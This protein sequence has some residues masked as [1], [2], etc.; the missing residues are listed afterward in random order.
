M[1]VGRRASSSAEIDEIEAAYLAEL[2]L[3]LPFWDGETGD[4]E[5]L[6][7][8]DFEMLKAAGVTPEEWEDTRSIGSPRR[9]K[10]MTN[11]LRTNMIRQAVGIA[12][13]KELPITVENVSRFLPGP[14]ADP[15]LKGAGG[16]LLIEQA[17]FELDATRSWSHGRRAN[18]HP[19]RPSF[20]KASTSRPV[21]ALPAPAPEKKLSRPERFALASDFAVQLEHQ[22]VD[23]RVELETANRNELDALRERN[24]IAHAFARVL[25]HRMTQ[26]QLIR[27]HIAAKMRHAAK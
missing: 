13:F 21:A 20:R 1:V 23:L 2:R 26:E 3:P 8:L 25:A 11:P 6:S 16:A 18:P 17:D 9:N 10:Q 5:P 19:L 7:H 4:L 14:H 24:E 12:T 22:R 27:Q 15:E